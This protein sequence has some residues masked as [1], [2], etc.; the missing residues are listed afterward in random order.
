[1]Y[2]FL[3]WWIDTSVWMMLQYQFMLPAYMI[4]KNDNWNEWLGSSLNGWKANEKIIFGNYPKFL[5]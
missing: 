1:M 2:T 4:K 3:D 5:C